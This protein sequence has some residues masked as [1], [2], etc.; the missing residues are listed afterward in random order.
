MSGR[1]PPGPLIPSNQ[2]FQTISASKAEL[3]S[4]VGPVGFFGAE[5]SKQQNG[6]STQD[7]SGAV[8]QASDH[9]AIISLT[10][11]L[12]TYGLTNHAPIFTGRT[13]TFTNNTTNSPALVLYVTVGG[14]GNTLTTVGTFAGTGSANSIVYP[15]PDQY[16]W[17][18][19][20][21]V[22]P[23]NEL[24]T[25]Q[26][27]ANL[28]EISVNNQTYTAGGVPKPLTDNWDIST[29]PPNVPD[30]QLDCGPR[31]QCVA[32]SY[33]KITNPGSGYFAGK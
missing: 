30:P 33:T 8:N 2:K 10:N 18:G 19:N 25:N 16:G 5:P 28:F 9:D 23:V 13:I 15:I 11:S 22:W 6:P 12:A 21:Q 14:K 24:P 3:G 7:D 32:A 4:V 26:L 17:N 1:S 29:V 27:G 31:D 20:F